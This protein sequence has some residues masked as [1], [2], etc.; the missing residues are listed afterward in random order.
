MSL[1][2]LPLCI[3]WLSLTQTSSAAVMTR[4][5]NCQSLSPTSFSSSEIKSSPLRKGSFVDE[6]ASS[7]NSV[8]DSAVNTN[9]PSSGT[10]E[11]S[12]KLSYARGE[13]SPRSAVVR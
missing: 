13:G 3:R 8:S 12:L 7:P 1:G 9:S 11:N 10:A 6:S 2:T 5:K 4:G